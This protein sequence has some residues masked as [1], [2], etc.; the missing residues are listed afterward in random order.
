MP[1]PGH[2][3][4]LP[5]VRQQSNGIKVKLQ[6]VTSVWPHRWPTCAWPCVT[7]I[8][9]GHIFILIGMFGEIKAFNECDTTLKLIIQWQEHDLITEPTQSPYLGK[10]QKNGIFLTG[11]PLPPFWPKKLGFQG[12]KQWPPKFHIKFRTPGPPHSYLGLSPN[13]FLGGFPQSKSRYTYS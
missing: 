13:F 6:P 11:E 12:Q 9:Q 3:L 7:G 1:Q 2:T 8:W 4:W 10:P 5:L